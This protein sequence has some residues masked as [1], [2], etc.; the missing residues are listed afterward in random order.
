[1]LNLVEVRKPEMPEDGWFYDHFMGVL[2]G[3]ELAKLWKQLPH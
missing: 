2:L 3:D 1:M